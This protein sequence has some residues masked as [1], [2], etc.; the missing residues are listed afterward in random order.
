MKWQKLAQIGLS[1]FCLALVTSILFPV[2]HRGDPPDRR[3]ICQ[4]NLKQTGLAIAQYLQDYDGRYPSLNVN[5]VATSVAP[6]TTPY[7]WADGIQPYL[8]SVQIFK[9]PKVKHPLN[10]IEDSVLNNFTD[11]Y[12]NTNL[13]RTDA[14]QLA[15]PAAT[16][17]LGEG[18]DGS[19]LT[20][21]RYNRNSLPLAWLH[22]KTMP[23]FRHLG[24]ANNANYGANYAF[25]DGHVKWLP[26]D[27]I[28]TARP[29]FE[30]ATFALN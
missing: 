19:D 15:M 2:L 28:I 18:N 25:V 8:K 4:S 29:A 27:R 21:A 1:L 13:D 17:L 3:G 30:G 7:G 20:D 12:L 9:C 11:Y 24:G 10:A 6:Y 16:L 14:K 23:S 22:D 5:A 26:P